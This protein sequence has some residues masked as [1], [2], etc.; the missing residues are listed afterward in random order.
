[1]LTLHPPEGIEPSRTNVN[2]G[3][4]NLTEDRLEIGEMPHFLGEEEYPQGSSGRNGKGS[5]AVAGGQI[6]NDDLEAWMLQGPGQHLTL[7]SSEVPPRDDGFHGP[8]LP[9]V[10]PAR[11][12]EP[13]A[14]R[15]GVGARVNLTRAHS[16][17][18][19]E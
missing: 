14:S 16:R 12:G 18:L 6:V 10:G 11:T 3:F 1:M 5:R 2:P 7:A 17:P 15:I 4:L 19:P 13:L 8:G 9:H